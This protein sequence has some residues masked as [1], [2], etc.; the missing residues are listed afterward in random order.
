[1]AVRAAL[2]AA[3]DGVESPLAAAV[4]GVAYDLS[5]AL[6]IVTVGALH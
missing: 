2:V 1:V 5:I 3:L 6:F 4:P